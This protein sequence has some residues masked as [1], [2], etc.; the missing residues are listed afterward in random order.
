MK[1]IG[2][3]ILC[4]AMLALSGN[5]FAAGT[6]STFVNP[7]QII[8]KSLP[9]H[10]ELQYSV[11]EGNPM[12]SGYFTVRMKFPKNYKDVVHSHEITR[13]DTIISGALYMGFGDK[14]DR[15]NV[16][17]L[18]TGA[19]IACPAHLK[20]YGFTDDETVVQISGMGPWEVL[21]SGG[22]AR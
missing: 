3:S 9:G 22:K 18:E 12:E 7:D 14:P 10:S 6:Q 8:W 20:H 1:N 2:Q 19:F 17:K 16:E 4:I 11:L 13:Y 15:K 21:K 5:I